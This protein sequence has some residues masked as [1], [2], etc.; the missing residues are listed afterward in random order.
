MRYNCQ[1]LINVNFIN[2]KNLTTGETIPPNHH[3]QSIKPPKSYS[4]I[5]G[6]LKILWDSPLICGAFLCHLKEKESLIFIWPI[7]NKWLKFGLW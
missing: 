7:Q 6:F 3:N 5:N 2:R 1:L 4:K